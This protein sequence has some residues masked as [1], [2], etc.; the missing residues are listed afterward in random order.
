M[1]GGLDVDE[2]TETG[3]KQGPCHV[4]ECEQEKRATAEGING[5]DSWECEQEVDKTESPGGE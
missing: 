2:S 4:G 5:P 1:S 3:G